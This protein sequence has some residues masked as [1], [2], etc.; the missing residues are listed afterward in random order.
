MKNLAYL[1]IIA[2]NITFSDFSARI[3]K[4]VSEQ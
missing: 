2:L 4:K 1:L 3:I